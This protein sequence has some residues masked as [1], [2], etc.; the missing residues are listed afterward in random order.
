MLLQQCCGLLYCNDGYKPIETRGLAKHS[1]AL[2]NHVLP[3]AD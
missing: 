2:F 3:V 1:S